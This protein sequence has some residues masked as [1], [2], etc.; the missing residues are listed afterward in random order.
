MS[1]KCVDHWLCGIVLTVL[2][3]RVFHNCCPT[4]W[5]SRHQGW[6]IMQCQMRHVFCDT[7]WISRRWWDCHERVIHDGIHKFPQQIVRIPAMP[8]SPC[9]KLETNLQPKL[10][11]HN[12]SLAN[13]WNAIPLAWSQ[14]PLTPWSTLHCDPSQRVPMQK[15]LILSAR[16][17]MSPKH[18]WFCHQ[19]V[20]I[21]AKISIIIGLAD[22]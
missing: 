17:V 6:F 1:M 11:T 15:P 8:V 12:S 13:L 9:A 14:Q 20:A 19:Y 2:A 3:T 21:K 10:M 18:G 5:R 16:Q 7:N 22:H 4:T